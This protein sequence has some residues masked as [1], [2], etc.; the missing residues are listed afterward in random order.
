MLEIKSGRQVGLPMQNDSFLEQVTLRPG[1]IVALLGKNGAGKTTLIE[2]IF[3]M[4]ERPRHTITLGGKP[5]SYKNLHRLALGS[6]E[7]T[8]FSEF[9]VLEQREFYEMNFPNFR[10]ERFDLL[11]EY[12]DI[13]TFWRMKD[14]SVGEQNQIETMFALCQGADYIFLDEP[15]ANSDLFHRKDFYKLLLGMLEETECLIISTHLIEEVESIIG[16]VLLMDK[17]DIIADVSMEEMDEDNT[18]V[19]TWLKQKL[20]YDEGKAAEFIR[21]ME[22]GNV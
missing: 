15:F 7:H 22:G 19:V 10:R 3:G 13:T 20:H 11:L 1:E 18:D 17:L 6:C 5:V 16:R 4:K 21:R 14:L 8:F 12:F 2:E 9:T